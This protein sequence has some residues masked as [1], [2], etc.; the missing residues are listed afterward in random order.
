L[1]REVEEEREG[2]GCVFATITRQ[3]LS[4]STSLSPSLSLSLCLSL[5]SAEYTTER[6]FIEEMRDFFEL[7]R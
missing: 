1:E 5:L 6:Q 3:L 7:D 4:S 2:D